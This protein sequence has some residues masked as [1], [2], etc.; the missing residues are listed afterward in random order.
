MK[1]Y[2]LSYPVQTVNFDGNFVRKLPEEKYIK[3]LQTLKSLGVNEVMIS[4]YVTV[5]E[6]DFDMDEATKRLG[7]LLDSFGMRPAQHHG[8]AAMFAPDGESQEQTIEKLTRSIQY[9]ANM[10]APVLVIHPGQVD[11]HFHTVQEYENYFFEQITKHG[12]HEF[13]KICA[14]NLDA[15]AEAGKKLGVKI[16]IENVHIFDSD[17]TLMSDLLSEVTS[18]NVGF[19]LDSG[20][21]HYK[22]APVMDWME[23]FQ[24]CLFTT[25]FHDNRGISDEHMPPGFGTIPWLDIISGLRKIGYQNTVNFE[26]QGWPLEKEKEGYRNAITFWRTLEEIAD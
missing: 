1:N 12:R 26:S 11:L 6:A 20:H 3:T 13:M 7:A 19:C 4:G 8:L 18:E 24:G 14:D 25:H 2:P 22:A 23:K 15:A 10:N 21:A 16:A 5:E 17:I 9:T